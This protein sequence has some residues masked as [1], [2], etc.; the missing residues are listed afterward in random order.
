MHKILIAEPIYHALPPAVYFNRIYF[1]QQCFALQVSRDIRVKPI[2]MG[3]RR[4]IRSARD[5]AKVTAFEMDA[6]HVLF[7]DDDIRVPPTLLEHLLA[8]DKPIVGGLIH[9]DDGVPI[10]FRDLG[11]KDDAA[12]IEIYA[13]EPIGEVPWMD[14]PKQ[15]AFECAA[16]A[17]GAM[18]IQVPV[19]RKLAENHRWLFNYDETSRSMDVR[20]CRM[21]RDAGFSVWCWP[22]EPCTQIQHY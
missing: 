5:L 10:V 3:P 7:L 13:G 4:A 14:H 8:V 22:D 1:W 11:L 2:V 21:A 19:L 17:A 16:V 20:F 12:A 18:L 6:T 9:R 15:G